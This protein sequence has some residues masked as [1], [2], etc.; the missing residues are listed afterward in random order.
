MPPPAETLE[1]VDVD[2]QGASRATVNIHGH[3]GKR[4]SRIDWKERG[5]AGDGYGARHAP[6]RSNRPAYR[7]P[8]RERRKITGS[9]AG[10]RSAIVGTGPAFPQGML[11]RIG[12]SLAVLLS[13]G[14]LL[15]E[16]QELCEAAA[17][18]VQACLGESAPALQGDACDQ[19]LASE[20]LS[21][22]CD[23]I[24]A[25]GGKADESGDSW[26]CRKLDIGCRLWTLTLHALDEA[27]GDPQE[28]LWVG[29]LVAEGDKV[30]V[31]WRTDDQGLFELSTRSRRDFHIGV[32]V[33]ISDPNAQVTG[34][35]LDCGNASRPEG[36]GLAL[37]LLLAPNEEDPYGDYARCEQ[38]E[39]GAPLAQ[40]DAP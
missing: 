15:A 17:E 7:P 14:C 4:S 6:G 30:I 27:T 19:E 32:R 38:V 24:G 13:S 36:S 5:P 1:N 9:A 35:W 18:H 37:D 39:A 22:S 8:G 11:S 2:V 29:E 10:G 12:S 21:M 31:Y 25:E 16:A 33:P 23:S 34:R 20:L 26:F 28:E 40:G 3:P